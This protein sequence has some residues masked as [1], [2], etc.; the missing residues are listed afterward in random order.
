MG[1]GDVTA[2]EREGGREREGERKG[3][4]YNGKS[5]RRRGKSEMKPSPFHS[6][7]SFVDEV[8][9]NFSLSDSASF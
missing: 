5:E 6:F 2:G 3:D 4:Q 1:T 7:I 9:R 8:K